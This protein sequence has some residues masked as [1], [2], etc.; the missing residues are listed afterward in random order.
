VRALVDPSLLDG[1]LAVRDPLR[2]RQTL[3]LVAWL[4][5]GAVALGA[6]LPAAAAGPAAPRRSVLPPLLAGG[7]LLGLW[8]VLVGLGA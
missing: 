3:I 1:A 7:A 5:A 6:L 8:G 4:A 2:A